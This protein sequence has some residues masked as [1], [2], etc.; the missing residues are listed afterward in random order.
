MKTHYSTLGVGREFEDDE[1]KTAWRKLSSAM[2]PDRNGGDR[3]LWDRYDAAR[4]II[5]GGGKPS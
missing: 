4:Q 2:H 1:L 3:T 5:E